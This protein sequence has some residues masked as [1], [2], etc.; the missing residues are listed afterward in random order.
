MKI[1]I[2]AMIVLNAF[3]VAMVLT[4]IA[5]YINAKEEQVK[6]EALY[7]EKSEAWFKELD[8]N[9]DLIRENERLKRKVKK[10]ESKK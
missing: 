5:L 4:F 1:L 6:A 2:T 8:R 9:I 10:L 3:L 7:S